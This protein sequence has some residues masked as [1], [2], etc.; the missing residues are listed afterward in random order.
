MKKSKEEWLATLDRQAQSGLSIEAFCRTYGVVRSNFYQARHRFLGTAKAGAT[1]AAKP[2][3]IP[4]RESDASTDTIE[5]EL[6]LGGSR[7]VLRAAS[8]DLARLLKAL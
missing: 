7:F 5:I 8:S 6:H 4:I 2:A 3:V 1:R